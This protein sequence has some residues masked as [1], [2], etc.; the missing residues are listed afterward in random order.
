MAL[1]VL[2]LSVIYGIVEKKMPDI[3]F[4]CEKEIEWGEG[5]LMKRCPHCGVENDRTP[6]INPVKKEET[7]AVD[8]N[9]EKYQGKFVYLPKI[10]DSA[11]FDIKEIREVQCDNEK[12]NFFE[13]V[14]VMANGEQV[15]DDEGEAVFKKKN[16][17]YH[18]EVEL[19]N[20]KIL[21]VTNMAAFLKVFKKYEIQDGEKV[22]IS[23]P[24]KG[25]WEVE[26]LS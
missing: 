17:G 14:P 16:L 2:W 23:H 15:I 9:Q 21:S 20:G 6:F 7:V 24:E 22:K 12:F 5:E 1:N 26:K 8:Y 25:S 3:C 19:K 11:E 4:L 18:V 10:G 13:N